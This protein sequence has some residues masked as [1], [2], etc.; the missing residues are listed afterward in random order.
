MSQLSEESIY[1]IVIHCL[2]MGQKVIITSKQSDE[3]MYDPNLVQQIFLRTLKRGIASSYILSEIKP[4][5]K[6]G[7]SC[8][9]ETEKKIL[10]SEVGKTKGVFL[11]SLLLN[12]KVIMS[13]LLQINA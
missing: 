7:N 13:H 10:P 1:Q 6:V 4:C 2:E 3:I 11:L 5:V 8:R 9:R 12:I